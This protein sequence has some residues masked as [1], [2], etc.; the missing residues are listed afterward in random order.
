MNKTWSEE[1]QESNDDADD[2]GDGWKG[3]GQVFAH[4]NMCVNIE[5]L[6]HRHPPPLGLSTHTQKAKFITPKVSH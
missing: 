5:K 6:L 2:D 1:N 3:R 4:K